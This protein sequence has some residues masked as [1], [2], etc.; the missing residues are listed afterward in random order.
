M[1]AVQPAGRLDRATAEALAAG[2]HRAPF[3]VLG[4]H[5]GPAGRIVRAFLP[6]ASSVEVLGRRDGRSLGRLAPGLVPGLFEG[7]VSEK[8]AYLLRIDWP[9]G[10]QETEDPYDYAPLLGELDLHL[11]NEG[12]H[13]DLADALGANPL[14]VAGVGGTRFAVWAPNAERVAVIGDFNAWDRT[15]HPMRLRYP[16]GVWRSEERRVGKECRS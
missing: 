14:T 13:F 12:R 2:R 9:G 5:D 8:A 1:N 7:P 15:R 16:A 10:V 3:D 4:P 6:G 11:F